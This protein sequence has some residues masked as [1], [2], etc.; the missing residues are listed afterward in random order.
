MANSKRSRWAGVFIGP[1]IAIAAVTAMWQN[2]ARFDFY[3]AARNTTAIQSPGDAEDGELISHT[4]NMDQDM[5]FRGEYV[6]NFQGY[7]VVNRRAEIYAW[8]E[9]EDDDGTTWNMKWSST[10]ESN[11]RN[12]GIQQQ[13]ASHR[14]VPPNYQI[15]DLVI[16][17]DWIEFVDPYESVS[18]PK[19]KLVNEKLSPKQDYFY[20][21][22]GKANQ[23]GDE[24]VSYT[25]I[26]IPATATYFGKFA[27]G[28][29]S[30]LGMGV[31]DKSNQRTGF[32]NAL[33]QDSGILHYIVAGQ[34]DEAL[35]S[36]KRY[37]AKIKWIVRGVG[38]LSLVGG[39]FIFFSTIFGFLIAIPIIGPIAEAGSFLLALVI[40]LPIAAITIVSSYLIAH[41][42]ILVL[43][44]GF[45]IAG[46]FYLGNRSRNTKHQI[47]QS[48]DQQF[49]RSLRPD[50]MKDLEFLELAQLALQDNQVIDQE[51]ALLR[52]WAD[53]HRWSEEKT[54]QMIQR[55]QSQATHATAAISSDEHLSNLIK[56]ALADG[57]LTRYEI[58]TIRSVAQRVGHD[59]ATIS[60][61]IDQVRR[62]PQ[63][64]N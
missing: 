8:Q 10:L 49:G 28:D 47:Q 37:I 63:L 5:S 16:K 41:P 42:I 15:G 22:K 33:I 7:L 55:A 40:G 20:L 52:Q 31:A 21:A 3:K 32:I 9:D 57:K 6:E 59:S 44:G 39:L 14:F 45:A 38:T 56:I 29:N 30:A 23:L 1:A 64:V 51:D 48:L 12:N 34:R 4:G 36:M 46:I 24:R 17:S 53:K 61:L 35:A 11:S 19:L 54:Q 60:S 2:E 50:D 25:G 18:L 43:L 62:S 58:K 27:A 13:L 26:P